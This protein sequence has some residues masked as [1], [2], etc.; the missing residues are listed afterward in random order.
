MSKQKAV[1]LIVVLVLIITVA[2]FIR[3][4]NKEKIKTSVTAPKNSASNESDSSVPATN[5]TAGEADEDVQA[6]ESDL[7]SIDDENFSGENLSDQNVGL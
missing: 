4:S 6:I 5:K 1:I 3:I 7:G 2:A